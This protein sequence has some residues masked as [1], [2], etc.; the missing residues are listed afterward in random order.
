MDNREKR[1]TA[2][3][4]WL[5]QGVVLAWGVAMILMFYLRN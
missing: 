3:A 5:M 1:S 2:L 4:S